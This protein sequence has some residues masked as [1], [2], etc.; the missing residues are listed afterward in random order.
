MSRWFSALWLLTATL[1]GLLQARDWQI[2]TSHS[3]VYFAV[4]HFQR[5]DIRGRLGDL[6]VQR[7]QFD[8]HGGALELTLA[9][10]SVD[11]GNRLLDQI[12][13]GTPLLDAEN[14]PLIQFRS[15]RLQLAAGRMQA[16]D[17]ELT[18]RGVRRP[19]QL[20]VRRWQC[21]RVRIVL[22]EREVCGGTFSASLKRSEFGISRYLPDVDDTVQLEI[23][24]EASP[25]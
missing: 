18:L 7:L 19:L 11:T 8:D 14:F 4:A 23:S 17:G 13:R 22:L 5:S 21:G 24:V 12:I 1:P 6:K 9:A 15:E 20:Q 25:R 3:S 2:D 16:V 10:D